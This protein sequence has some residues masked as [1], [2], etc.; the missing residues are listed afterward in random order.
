MPPEEASGG[1]FAPKLDCYVVYRYANKKAV[2][3]S[4]AK[5]KKE[6]SGKVGNGLPKPAPLASVPENEAEDGSWD[7]DVAPYSPFS[8]HSPN[9]VLFGRFLHCI[10]PLCEICMWTRHSCAELSKASGNAGG[11]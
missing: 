11:G 10:L 9:N 5:A 7:D 2:A 6:S 3:R 1:R 8:M 4:N